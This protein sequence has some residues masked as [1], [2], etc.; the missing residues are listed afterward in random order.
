M[1]N[2]INA[3]LKWRFEGRETV[4]TVNRV[5]ARILAPA[6]AGCE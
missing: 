4:E 5:I 6:E 2:S 1:Q 3:V